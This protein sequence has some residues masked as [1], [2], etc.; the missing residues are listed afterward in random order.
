M[1]GQILTVGKNLN[2]TLLPND[3]SV[4]LEL[5]NQLRWCSLST[6]VSYPILIIKTCKVLM[7]LVIAQALPI[8]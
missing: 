6:T 1:T 4:E 3:N 2:S 5:D 7:M 8:G